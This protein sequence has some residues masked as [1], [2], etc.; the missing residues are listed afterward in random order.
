MQMRREIPQAGRRPRSCP[1]MK[2]TPRRRVA[3]FSSPTALPRTGAVGLRGGPDAVL[4][5][6]RR[7]GSI[8]FDPIAVAGRSHDLVLHARVAGY[9]PAWCDMLYERREIFEA[10]NKALSFV[11]TSE[12]PWFRMSSGRKG[13]GS[14]P[15][16]SPRTPRSPS[17]CSSGSARRAPLSSRDF[18]RER[19]ATKD[20]FGMPENAVRAVLEAYTVTGVIGLARRDGN[21]RYYDLLE[22]LLPAEVLA[23][24]VPEREQLRHKLLSRYR[25]HGLL[26]A[27]GAGGTFARI[28]RES[29]RSGSGERAAQGTHRARRARAGR[30]RGRARQAVCCSPRSSR[31]CR[32]RRSRRPPSR[33][34]PRSTRCCGT[35]PCSRACSASSTCGRASSRRRSAL[36]AATCFRS[37]S[38]TASSA[39]S[40]R[41]STGTEA[42][43][44]VLGVWWEDG[45]APRRADGFVDAM[46]D[47]L[48][49]YLRFA[50]AAASS[51]HPSSERRSGSS[52]PARDRI[53]RA[54][55]EVDAHHGAA[56]GRSA[57]L[58]DP[59]GDRRCCR[60]RRG[61]RPTEHPSARGNH[62]IALERRRSALAREVH[63]GV[64]ERVARTGGPTQDGILAAIS[65]M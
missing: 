18:E 5:V 33:S 25:A 49:A 4:E 10:T 14:T 45:F 30:G 47:A 32:R 8:Q 23:Q 58:R 20:W 44:E 41:G 51:G 3:F 35:P 63:G 16:S 54:L 37:S 59:G 56:E 34:S 36:G 46:R 50:G 55:L 31:C 52:S 6:L 12:F 28:A 9:E 7:L 65:Q 11:P 43:V 19:G 64:G 39:G 24:E 48:R 57:D 29:T 40:N 2:I 22:R 61:A 17:G 42:R 38:A 26:G 1:Q 15:R 62:R 60:G 21:R 53:V 13:R 27:G